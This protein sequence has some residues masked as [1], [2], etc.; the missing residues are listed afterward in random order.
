ML[1]SE[2]ADIDDLGF[3]RKRK[4]VLPH[5]KKSPLFKA[6]HG[7]GKRKDRKGVEP[8]EEPEE[9]EENEVEAPLTPPPVPEMPMYEEPPASEE[10]VPEGEG[11]PEDTGPEGLYG[12]GRNGRRRG[13]GGGRGRWGGGG[14]WRRRRHRRPRVVHYYGGY[15]GYGYGY[16]AYYEEAEPAEAPI[17]ITIVDDKGNPVATI[18]GGRILEMKPGYSVKMSPLPVKMSGIF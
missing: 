6:I 16:P 14:E 8:P 12:L 4:G 7:E 3:G 11:Y 13:G 5:E 17:P 2:F 15:P 10:P 18:I 1:V 9:A